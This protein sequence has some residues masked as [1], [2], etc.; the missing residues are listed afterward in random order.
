[1]NTKNQFRIWGDIHCLLARLL[2]LFL[3]GNP[4]LIGFVDRFLIRRRLE[5]CTLNIPLKR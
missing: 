4:L 2:G 1:M 3:Q 5:L